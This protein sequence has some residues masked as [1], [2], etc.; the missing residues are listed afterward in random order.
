MKKIS[1]KTFLIVMSSIVLL[2]SV[3]PF[4]MAELEEVKLP[5]MVENFFFAIMVLSFMLLAFSLVLLDHRKN[6][7]RYKRD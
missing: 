1:A 6:G 4:Y 3:L 5:S 7:D 2:L